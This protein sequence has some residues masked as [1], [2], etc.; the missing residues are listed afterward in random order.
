MKP[1]DRTRK[2]QHKRNGYTLRMTVDAIIHISW[3]RR[4]KQDM[5]REY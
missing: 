3:V 5:K 1:G 4:P 2:Y